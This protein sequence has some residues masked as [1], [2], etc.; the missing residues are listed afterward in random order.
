LSFPL[1]LP[2]LD[3]LAVGVPWLLVQFTARFFLHHSIYGHYHA[4][5]IALLFAATAIGAGRIGR[6][7]RKAAA[8]LLAALLAFS[9]A[10]TWKLGAL[11]GN[12]RGTDSPLYASRPLDAKQRALVADVAATIGPDASLAVSSNLAFRFARHRNARFPLYD[13]DAIGSATYILV[14][15]RLPLPM[16][17]ADAERFQ[18]RLAQGYRIVS[19]AGGIVLYASAKPA[20]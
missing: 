15:T 7:S 9:I 18:G 12:P 17:K 5:L 10:A 2:G 14:D 8:A 3:V 6:R 16:S 4:Q 19:E 13:P 20:R 11:S 1:A